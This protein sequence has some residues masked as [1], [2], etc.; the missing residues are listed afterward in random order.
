MH[1]DDEVDPVFEKERPGDVKRHL[2]DI[3]KARRLLKFRPEV[4]I[5]DGIGKYIEWK[6]RREK[7]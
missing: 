7:K 6:M 5:E 2:A 4:C 1:M 3:S